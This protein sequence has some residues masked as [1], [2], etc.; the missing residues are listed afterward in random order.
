MNQPT[1]GPTK[2]TTT[3]QQQTTTTKQQI[4]QP[5]DE[6]MK[7][8]PKQHI[9]NETT[10][11]TIKQQPNTTT[12]EFGAPLIYRGGVLLEDIVVVDESHRLVLVQVT[13]F[14][15]RA[16]QTRTHKVRR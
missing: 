3:K 11:T 15:V 10:E 4:N 13:R 7:Q 16:H 5:Q 1:A 6:T 2:Q 14:E 12:T 9:N 8:Q